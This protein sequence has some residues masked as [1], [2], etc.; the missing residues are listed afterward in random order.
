[1][2]NEP[3]CVFPRDKIVY[4]Y[5]A[6]GRS[7]ARYHIY[8]KLLTPVIGV[9]LTD[10]AHSL[11]FDGPVT[12][13]P[14]KFNGRNFQSV[15][16]LTPASADLV[17]DRWQRVDKLV[18]DSLFDNIQSRDDVDMFM[19]TLTKEDH[20][21]NFVQTNRLISMHLRLSSGSMAV[22]SLKSIVAELQKVPRIHEINVMGKSVD[23]QAA[24]ILSGLN[25][26]ASIIIRD[27]SISNDILET[28]RALLPDCSVETCDSSQE[29][30]DYYTDIASSFLAQDNLEAAFH[31]HSEQ[32]RIGFELPGAYL[33][34]GAL[35]ADLEDYNHA[36]DDYSS[37]IQIDPEN[38]LAYF[39]RGDA[40]LS[41][42]ESE[43]AIADF[44]RAIEIY[45]EHEGAYVIRGD[46]Y[47][48]LE[49]YD[50]AIADF[51]RAIEIDPEYEGA[52]VI[53][54]V[55]Y[56]NLNEYDKALDDCHEAIRLNLDFAAAYHWLGLCNESLGN[57]IRAEVDFS[58]ALELGY[59][60]EDE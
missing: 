4:I 15:R 24:L 19:F 27:I 23:D 58:K 50:K 41:L 21:L 17:N 13:L 7:A 38:T 16:Q 31:E 2:V 42:E 6:D 5:E 14:E 18:L 36:I 53:R 3:F 32:I 45:P 33:R 60:P 51:S 22:D 1:M 54:G 25:N 29:D 40:Y 35:C 55:A 20:S 37:A 30:V 10:L 59:D 52:Y 46:T 57:S 34:R 39:D 9:E 47:L 26:V 12:Q 8:Q 49:E 44:S 56:Y 28:L 48:S 43:K 11:R